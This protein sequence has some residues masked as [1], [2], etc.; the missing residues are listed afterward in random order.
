MAARQLGLRA[1][2]GDR[3]ADALG[4]RRWR[5][6]VDESLARCA[7]QKRQAECLNSAKPRKQRDALL[8]RLAKADAGIE[9]DILARDAG[10]GRD[11]ERA[12]EESLAHRP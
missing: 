2:G 7:D 3:A 5:D 9:H 4:R 1:D 8:R 10:A 11:L 6:G 12:G